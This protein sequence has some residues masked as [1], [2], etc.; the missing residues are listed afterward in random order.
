MIKQ[1][2]LDKHGKPT[3]STPATWMQEY[4]DYSDSAKRD[5]GAKGVK[6][7]QEVAEV[8]KAPRVVAEAVKTPKVRNV[9]QAGG[10][11]LWDTIVSPCPSGFAPVTGRGSARQG[12]RRCR[13]TLA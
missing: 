10:S 3:D 1:G 13:A 8:V 12:R 9:L 11:A 6:D 2:L 7:P 4:V 5:V